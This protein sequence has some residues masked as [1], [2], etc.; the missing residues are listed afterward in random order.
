MKQNVMMSHSTQNMFQHSKLARILCN[1]K[2]I[3]WRKYLS[4]KMKT[5][6]KFYSYS[7]KGTGVVGDFSGNL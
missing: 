3:C 5:C 7:P 1:T 4:M 2:I 6:K